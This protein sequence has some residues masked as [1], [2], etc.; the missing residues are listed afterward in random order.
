MNAETAKV[1]HFG[2]EFNPVHVCFHYAVIMLIF[3]NIT[4]DPKCQIGADK[5]LILLFSADTS[6]A[7][8]KEYSPQISQIIADKKIKIG[9]STNSVDFM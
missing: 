1:K 5:P 4:Y 8:R 7:A 2:F 6:S 9:S 3:R